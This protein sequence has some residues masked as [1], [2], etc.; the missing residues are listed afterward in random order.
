MKATVWNKYSMQMKPGFGFFVHIRPFRLCLQQEKEKE[1][2]EEVQNKF[3]VHGVFSKINVVVLELK[4]MDS[5]IKHFNKVE[6]G[7]NELLKCYR[8]TNQEKK[9]ISMQTI[10]LSFF[11]TVTYSNSTLK[12]TQLLF[13][14]PRLPNP[15]FLQLQISKQRN[16]KYMCMI[17]FI[18][19][20]VVRCLIF[21][22]P[23]V[24]A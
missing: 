24:G 4:A 10:L 7:M 15:D 1:R 3:T 14:R 18:N 8:E 19:K 2:A 6:S 21:I 9:K 20:N 12:N 11:L 16:D 17:F 13:H 22:I 5:N 23:S